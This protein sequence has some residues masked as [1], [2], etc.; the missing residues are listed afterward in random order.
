MP[1]DGTQ[2]IF[3]FSAKDGNFPQHFQGTNRNHFGF[4][5]LISWALL[6][7]V[8]SWSDRNYALLLGYLTFDGSCQ[9]Q[10][11]YHTPCAY[12]GSL[13]PVHRDG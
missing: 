2:F 12:L 8:L 5:K 10:E 13:C 11:S 9:R 3:V 7:P 6:L 1:P 4:M